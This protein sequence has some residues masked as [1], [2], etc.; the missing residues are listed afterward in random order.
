MKVIWKQSLYRVTVWLA[1]EIILNCLGIDNLADYSEFVFERNTIDF[2]GSYYFSKTSGKS[3]FALELA[4]I[5]SNP[6]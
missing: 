1:A 3:Q 2:D 6:T 4:K 5:R